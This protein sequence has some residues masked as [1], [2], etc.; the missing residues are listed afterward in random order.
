MVISLFKVFAPKSNKGVEA[1]EDMAE[2]LTLHWVQLLA[3][4]P[5]IQDAK[6]RDP[7]GGAVVLHQDGAA[8]PPAGQGGH[9]PLEGVAELEQRLLAQMG[10]LPDGVPAGHALADVK[11]TVVRDDQAGGAHALAHDDRRGP[12]VWPVDDHRPAFGR[13]PRG[14]KCR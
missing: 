4:A 9:T 13:R 7:P 3:V 8:T 1:A 5:S 10:H 14:S 12:R 11:G 2:T 6:S